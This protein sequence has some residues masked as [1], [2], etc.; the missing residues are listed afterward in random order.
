[1]FQGRQTDLAGKPIETEGSAAMNRQEA[2][3]K[4]IQAILPE[5]EQYLSERVQKRIRA[6]GGSQTADGLAENRAF[7]SALYHAKRSDKVYQAL[8]RGELVQEYHL[9]EFELLCP[10]IQKENKDKE[11]QLDFVRSV[12][13]SRVSLDSAYKAAGFVAHGE[14]DAFLKRDQKH[15]VSI[16]CAKTSCFLSEGDLTS[17][18]PREKQTG[19]IIEMLIRTVFQ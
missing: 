16:A 17:L 8:I 7:E 5:R 2:L 13:K 11:L 12:Q 19:N 6:G 1:M 18:I 14:I 15:I 3:E 10:Y 4:Y 9:T